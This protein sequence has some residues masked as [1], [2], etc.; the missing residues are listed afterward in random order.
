MSMQLDYLQLCMEIHS[1]TPVYMCSRWHSMQR[2]SESDFL[3]NSQGKLILPLCN[4]HLVKNCLNWFSTSRKK[5]NRL[6]QMLP[7]TATSGYSHAALWQV[8]KNIASSPTDAS[9][10]SSSLI[11]SVTF[12]T[13]AATRGHDSSSLAFTTLCICPTAKGI[14]CSIC[15]SCAKLKLVARLQ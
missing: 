3:P 10:M 9:R 2:K 7:L 11:N 5:S 6:A 1:L 13:K 8:C 15:R 12:C 14:D 4:Q